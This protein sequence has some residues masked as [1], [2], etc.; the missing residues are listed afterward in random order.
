MRKQK[1]FSDPQAQMRPKKPLKAGGH[2]RIIGGKWRGR[3]LSVPSLPGLRPTPDRVRETLFNWLAVD[4]QG[5]T[6]CDLFC[7]SGALGFE[8]A[9]RGA[10][11]VTLVDQHKKVALQMAKNLQ[12]IKTE[13]ILFQQRNVLDFLAKDAGPVE[14]AFD[15]I[16]LDPPFEQ[17]LIAP[18]ITLLEQNGWLKPNSIIYIESES[19]ITTLTVPQCWALY[20]EKISGQVCYRLYHRTEG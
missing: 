12:L 19:S 18:C 7:G 2:I 13:N 15:I 9:S 5:A 6:C 1:H 20:R 17:N 3:K 10:A 4:I 14:R 16:F 11:S 8:A